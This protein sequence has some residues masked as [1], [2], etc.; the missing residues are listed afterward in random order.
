MYGET[1]LIEPSPQHRE[2]NP[3]HLQATRG[4]R[5]PRFS[6]TILPAAQTNR[7]SKLSKQA[8]AEAEAEAE[9]PAPQAE[10]AN[11]EARKPSPPKEDP[12]RGARSRPPTGRPREPRRGQ[13]KQ[14]ALARPERGSVGISES[15]EFVAGFGGAGAGPSRFGR[16]DGGVRGEEEGAGASGGW[17]LRLLPLRP[18]CQEP[19][20]G[21]LVSCLGFFLGFY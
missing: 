18:R 9:P 21:E 14:P 8:E 20:I 2:A 19:Q 1:S 6:G 10:R 17:P 3:T 4:S 15:A 13:R 7:A 12:S 16:E 11:S 5:P